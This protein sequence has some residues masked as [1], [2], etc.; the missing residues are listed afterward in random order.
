MAFNA[1]VFINKLM[2]E[3]SKATDERDVERIGKLD[4][5]VRRLLS[6][7]SL[8]KT[9]LSSRLTDLKNVHDLAIKLVHDEAHLVQSKMGVLTEN[10]DGLR[11]YY[12]VISQE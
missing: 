8:D 6:S 1:E 4:D 12:E 11:G 10:Q 5:E 9:A 2:K 3:F 7:P